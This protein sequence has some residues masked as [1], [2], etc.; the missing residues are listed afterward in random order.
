MNDGGGSVS[1]G[2]STMTWDIGSVSRPFD[3][4]ASS[5]NVAAGMP[6]LQMNMSLNGSGGIVKT[7]PGV[8][9]LN[10]ATNNFSSQLEIQNGVVRFNSANALT[11]APPLLVDGG[12]MDISSNNQTFGTVTMTAGTIS[13]STTTPSAVAAPSFTLNVAAGSKAVAKAILADSGAGSAT[14][15]KSGA[16]SAT[17]SGNNTYT[18]VTTV[19]GGRL[20][21]A[22]TGAQTPV[23]TGAAG[24][25]ITGGRLVLDYS[26][27]STP[28][29]TVKSLL[30]AAAASNFASGQIRSSTATAT[31]GLGWADNAAATQVTIAY[32][33][34]GD[35]NCDGQVD[36]TDLGALATNWQ[37]ASVW[38]GGDFNYDGFVDVTD[39]GTLATNWQAGVGNPLGPGSFQDALASVG[40]GGVT[41]P[42][43]ATLSVLSI[44]AMG[45]IAR[46]RRN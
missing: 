6:D 43:P 28:A 24:A 38:A 15:T 11:S 18:G 23:L 21:L 1:L 7:G 29:T 25:N 32:T 12:E 42:E 20:I 34:K 44:G 16:G 37:T 30:T 36:V 13:T 19:Q 8:L 4:G 31:K 14:V 26:G 9:K 41:V 17:L 39:L 10:N 40:L 45:L 35:A 22:G 3:I 46:R 27:G 5:A 2:N 33:Y